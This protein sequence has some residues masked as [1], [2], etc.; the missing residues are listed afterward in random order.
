VFVEEFLAQWGPSP[1]V[2]HHGQLAKLKQEGK[3][4]AYIEEFRQLQTLVRGWSDDALM[5][6]FVDGLKPWIANEVKMRQPK[7]LQEAMKM[8]KLMEEHYYEKKRVKEGGGSKP[9]KN[10]FSKPPEKNNEAND[11]PSENTK[12]YQKLSKE[13]VQD[14]IKK[15]L[16]F[17][18]GEK[19]S[20]DHKCRKGQV[21]VI[22]DTSDDDNDKTS[23]EE[24][25]SDQ[26]DHMAII[27][28][29][30][31]NDAELSLN[32][33][34]GTQKPTTM[35]LMAWIGKHEVSLLVDSG[36]SHNFVNPNVMKR[37]GMRGSEIEPFDVRVANGEKLQCGEVVNDVKMNVQGVRVVADLHVL[38]VVGLDVV[39]GNAWLRGL[40]RV[41]HNYEDMIIE[42]HLKGKKK[43]KDAITLDG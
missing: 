41:L 32:A 20:R 11:G 5:G 30:S 36:P 1:S 43:I 34:T 12:E 18:C 23:S 13:E 19:W 15:C 22:E 6:T 39:L 7:K 2:N 9:S 25:S 3:V 10:L 40:G 42:F 17:K 35:R 33:L 21:L 38:A 37:V 29:S 24:D 14:R 26:A 28:S 8:A 27:E 31:D 16:C 4:A